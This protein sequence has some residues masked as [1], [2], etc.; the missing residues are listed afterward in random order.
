MLSEDFVSSILR[1]GKDIF[2][3]YRTQ[4]VEDVYKRQV[5]QR[6]FGFTQEDVELILRPMMMQG[7]EPLG[8]MGNDAPLAV[9]SGKAPLLDVYKRQVENSG[10][11]GGRDRARQGP[12]AVPF[13]LRA[14]AC[15]ARGPAKLRSSSCLLY[16][17][18][19]V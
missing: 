15:P 19:C 3:G 17:S 11:Q 5:H 13:P 7:A 18:R 14:E 4:G 16:T 12:G 6:Q 2:I 9:L 8:S 1:Q 10:K